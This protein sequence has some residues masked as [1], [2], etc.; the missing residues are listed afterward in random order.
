MWSCTAKNGW[1]GERKESL[2]LCRY[3]VAV[4]MLIHEPVGKFKSIYFFYLKSLRPSWAGVSDHGVKDP[5]ESNYAGSE[6]S[7]NKIL[8]GLIPLGI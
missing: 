1:V 4:C 2:V 3:C 7:W 6:T 5:S 8:R